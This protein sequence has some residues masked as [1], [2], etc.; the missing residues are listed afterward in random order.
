MCVC[1]CVCGDLQ[2]Q[3]PNTSEIK[4]ERPAS[5]C[6]CVI[7]DHYRKSPL[8]DLSF[9]MG[10]LS[11]LCPSLSLSLTHTHTQQ[12]H[13][14]TY[15]TNTMLTQQ[16]IKWG[17]LLLQPGKSDQPCQG[18]VRCLSHYVIGGRYN[19]DQALKHSRLPNHGPS[20]NDC[21]TEEF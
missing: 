20:V 12:K 16:T 11:T 5:L 15:T 2:T 4:S 9:S 17:Y 1:V 13:T 21:A 6:V 19:G 7:K 8:K 14:N 18:Q 10:K 3:K